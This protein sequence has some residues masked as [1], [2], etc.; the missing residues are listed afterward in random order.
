MT[1]AP[2]FWN[3]DNLPLRTLVQKRVQKS[4]LPWHTH[5]LHFCLLFTLGLGRLL[6]NL[7]SCYSL[8]PEYSS[9]YCSRSMFCVTPPTVAVAI[10]IFHSKHKNYVNTCSVELP[11]RGVR[12]MN[13]VLTLTKWHIALSTTSECLRITEE[14]SECYSE[15]ST[16]WFVPFF[17]IWIVIAST[18]I[19]L[20]WLKDEE[21]KA[22]HPKWKEK[23]K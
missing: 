2:S 5:L 3:E 10:F 7:W 6:A 22:L 9:K 23:K 1:P 8:V 15:C 18:V 13:N 20:A 14:W 21:R 12:A 19:M 11:A 16:Q 4:G 17:R